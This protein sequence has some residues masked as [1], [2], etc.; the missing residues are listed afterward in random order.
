LSAISILL[1]DK[2]AQSSEF[3]F[4]FGGQ[5]VVAI[6]CIAL[7]PWLCV[8]AFQRVCLYRTN[9]KIP[10]KLSLVMDN[11][12]QQNQLIDFIFGNLAIVTV[13]YT[14]LDPWLCV[15]VFQQVCYF[16]I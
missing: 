6:G 4:A 8:P 10:K 7:D 12:A 3:G 15:P 14:A 16:R 13:Y 1:L 9:N 2:G 5:A 11:Q